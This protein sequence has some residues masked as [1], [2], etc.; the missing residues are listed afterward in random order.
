MAAEGGTDRVAVSTKHEHLFTPLI[1]G[2]PFFLLS[3]VSPP[4]REHHAAHAAGMQLG[5]DVRKHGLAAEIDQRLPVTSASL[6]TSEESMAAEVA[7]GAYG[8]VLAGECG[9]LSGKRPSAR[10]L[11]AGGGVE[12]ARPRGDGEQRR[13][14]AA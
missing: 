5:E 8:W 10:H 9:Q 11:W 7:T 6:T 4:A 3:L 12:R 1:R 13:R 2:A 14:D